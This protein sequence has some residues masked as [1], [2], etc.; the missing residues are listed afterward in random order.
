MGSIKRLLHKLFID[1]TPTFSTRFSIVLGVLLLY[2]IAIIACATKT[3]TVD[4]PHYEELISKLK[5]DSV[6]IPQIRG[7]IYSESGDMIAASAPEYDIFFDF[8]NKDNVWYKSVYDSIKHKKKRVATTLLPKD[9]IDYYFS[10]NGPAA[11]WMH[12]LNPRKTA[13]EHALGMKKA[14]REGNRRYLALRRISYLE[15]KELRNS[16]PFFSKNRNHIGMFHEDR[17]HRKRPYG[18]YRMAAATIGGVFSTDTF[19]VVN[20]V[21]KNMKGHGRNGLE[22]TFDSLLNGEPGIGFTEK[23]KLYR[24]TIVQR[25]PIDGADV[26]TTLDMEMQRILD[27]E[28]HKRIIELNAAGGWAAVM[29]TKT[30]K[31][32]AISNLKHTMGTDYC[33]EDYNHFVMDLYDPGSTFKTVSYT[34]LLDD[35]KITP[36]TEVDTGNTADHPNS[37]NYH[38]KEIRDDHPV[39]KVTADEA[40]VQSSNIS[41]AKLT[42]QAYEK[43]K[44]RYLDL[45]NNMRIFEDLHLDVEFQGAQR[46]RN[47]K[48]GDAT[49][50]KVSLGQISYG[51]ET[52]I[53]GMYMLNFYNAIANNGKLMRPY[54]VD[55]VVKDGQILYH[56]EPEVINPSI[57]KESTLK[58][59]RHALE[60]VVERG[61]A[62]GNRWLPG[63]YTPKVKIAGKT[64]TA[65]RY[66]NHSYS[67]NGHYV[68]FAGYFPADDPQY[69]CIVVIDARPGGNFGRPGGGYMAGPVFRNFAEQ[70]YA[71]NY[72]RS[73]KEIQPDSANVAQYG[74]YPKAKRGPQISTGEVT[75]KLGL[76]TVLTMMNIRNVNLSNVQPGIVPDVEGMGAIDALYMLE[77]AGLRVNISGHGKVVS[78][79][80]VAGST[81]TKGQTITIT[82]K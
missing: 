65:Q 56:R 72:S 14:Y 28:L 30:G 25:E 74:M 45:I 36:D 51:Y 81:L 6:S 31:I 59:V 23:V 17:P 54:I 3:F 61:T 34:V 22:Q 29:E 64:G 55:R 26:Y 48:V 66:A 67:G 19:R 57:C 5:R 47:R 15:Y 11:Q 60:G 21:K 24:Q 12:K 71:S 37:W 49:W 27:S 10:P 2:V 69:T 77:S 44:Q 78:Q 32:K 79:S 43:D 18:E 33:S 4:R 9:T 35:G 39:G 40:M 52:R 82:L 62:H 50:S 68:S 42:T 1:W 7:V 41:L 16:A 8:R 70:V 53:P 73:Y 46:P 38:G 20:G 63:A 58:A 80:L 13:A 75:G 76:D